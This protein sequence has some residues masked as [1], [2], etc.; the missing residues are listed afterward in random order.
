MPIARIVLRRLVVTLALLL[1][2]VSLAWVLT[3]LAPGDAASVEAG[4]PVTAAASDAER[5]Q[6][7]ATGSVLGSLVRWWAR[8]I[9]LDFGRSVR[10]QR[11][12]LP[13]VA[14]R[15]RRSAVLT[16]CAMGIGLAVG[17]PLG[18]LSSRRRGVLAGIIRAVSVATLSCPPLVLA[19]LLT[20]LAATSRLTS[21][22]SSLLLPTLALAL[23]LA[24]TFERL[25]SR[26]LAEVS[27]AACLRA[28]AG[29]GVAGYVVTWKHAWRLAL[30]PVASLGGVIAG[31]LLGGAL[32][33]EVITAWPGLGRLAFEALL[34]RDGPLVAGCAAM[35]VL[36]VSGA[37][38]ASDLIVAWADPRTREASA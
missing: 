11:P 23:P 20:W 18:V 9:R 30:P 37:A 19:L 10:F 3:R 16:A 2:A 17:L 25:Q 24:A 22:S 38:L 21:L 31:A 28:A 26:A 27:S 8:A 34:S 12:V 14:E 7:G 6:A 4:Q 13:L 5:A 29:R 36:V 15:A 35:T 32:S 1:A 33:V